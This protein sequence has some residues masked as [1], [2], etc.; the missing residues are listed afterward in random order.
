MKPT[1]LASAIV[2]AA[3]MAHMTP[4]CRAEPP[5]AAPRF[6]SRPVSLPQD[7]A[8]R[9]AS[10]TLAP[11]P[12]DEP[13]QA[14]RPAYFESEVRQ[15]RAVEQIRKLGGEVEYTASA[16]RDPRNPDLLLPRVVHVVLDRPWRGGDEGLRYIRQLDDLKRLY[17]IDRAVS[18]EAVQQLAADM[19]DLQIQHRGRACLGVA[20]MPGAGCLIT[21]VQPRSAADRAGIQPGDVITRLDGKPLPNFDAMLRIMQDYEPGDRVELEINRRG[22]R[23][24]LQVT[25]GGWADVAAAAP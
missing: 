9:P 4:V 5:I 18:P 16:V 11:V 3:A 8:P 19:P 25:M 23:L 24:K 12:S 1:W 22:H 7:A 15:R 20:G 13:V 17:I 21:G 14:P 6:D 2:S 10:G